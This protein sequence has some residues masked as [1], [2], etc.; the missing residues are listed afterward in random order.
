MRKILKSKRGEGYIDVILMVFC[1]VMVL[2]LA[3]NT[4]ELLALKQNMDH[5]G[6]ELIA[7]ATTDGQISANITARQQALSTETGINPTLTWNTTYFNASQRTVQF[8]K[9]IE[10]TLTL[11]T[12]F[13]GFGLFSVPVTLTTKH[14][15]LSQR[16]WKS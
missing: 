1:A 11:S 7:T 2:V 10:L 4:F 9:K 12:K 14:S 5:Y 16:Y 8:G 15:G 13:K 3:L 6:K